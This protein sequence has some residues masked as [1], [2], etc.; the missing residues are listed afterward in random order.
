M[1]NTLD[2]IIGP[3]FSGKTTRL[4][5]VLNKVNQ[6]NK[7]NKEENI[8]F[9][10]KPDIDNRYEDSK[11][12]NHIISHDGFRSECHVVG[13]LLKFKIKIDSKVRE[14]KTDENKL[15]WIIIDEGQFFNDLKMFCE[16]I[17]SNHSDNIK[18]K[19]VISGLDGDFKKEPI[20]EILSLIPI[21]DSVTK[22]NGKCSYCDS[23]SIMSKRICNEK[24]QVLIGG[25][26]M[27]KPTCRIHHDQF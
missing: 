18:Y 7:K 11:E 13:N 17:L 26:D 22:L 15:I 5:E 27:Y 6:E 8:L 2:L 16:D 10:I 19:I 21:S 25:N 23:P 24:S 12:V 1:V 3:M 20:G 4:L 14:L 9:I